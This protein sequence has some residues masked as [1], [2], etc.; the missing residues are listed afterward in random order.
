MDQVEAYAREVVAGTVPAGKYHRLACARHLRDLERVGTPEFPYVFVWENADRFLKFARCL[1]HYKGR[2]FA[3]KPFEPTP[4]QVF[5]LGS[6]FGWRHATTGL[7]RFTTSYNEVPRKQGKSFEAAAVGL[8][9]TFFE[10]EPGAEGYCIATKEEQAKIVFGDM[11]Q[12][13]TTSGLSSRIKVN[14]ANLHRQANASKLEPLGSDSDTTDGLNPHF[15][16]VDELH[17]FKKRGLL[18]VME[19]ATGARLNPLFYE[20]TTAGDD[21]VS[22][23]GDQHA[24]ACQILDQAIDEDASTLSFFACIAHADTEREEQQPDGTIVKIPG[25]DWLDEATWQKANPHWGI[26]V[27]PEDMRK[28]AA[29]AKQM[30]SAAAEFKQKRLNIWINATAPCLSIDGWRAGQSAWSPDDMLHEPCY[31][32]ID[33][34]SKIDFATLSFAFPPSPGRRQWRIL[35]YIWTP[36]DTLRERARRD[37]APYEVWAEQGWLIT[38]P[39]TRIDQNAIKA[40]LLEERERFDIERAGFDPWHADKLIDEL[41]DPE[42]GGFDKEQ[43]LAVPQTYAGMSSGCLEMQ[44][45]I[46]GGNVDA[47]SC[48]VTRLA[49]ANTVG[50]M[51]GKENLM[52]AK[53]KSRGRIDPIVAPTIGMALWKRFGETPSNVYLTRGVRTLGT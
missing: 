33:L 26:S 46:L 8:Y 35:N 9:A 21:P 15:V 45:E 48:P 39:G 31:V 37:R 4:F 34:A 41:T 12:L 28:L 23:C 30:P 36:A 19:S 52:F 43:I 6:V 22:V 7:R 32:G 42:D 14:A 49:V 3:G 13:V 47:R 24:Y 40:K 1:K 53:G 18:D 50:Q 17:K 2:Q 25:D 29:K 38:C 11:K 27:N 51:D 10:G 16:C 44:A 5:R 20:I